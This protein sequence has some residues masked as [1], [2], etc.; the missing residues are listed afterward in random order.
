MAIFGNQ[1]ET[2]VHMDSGELVVI[3]NETKE[4]LEVL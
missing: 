3:D 2:I 4:I 1:D